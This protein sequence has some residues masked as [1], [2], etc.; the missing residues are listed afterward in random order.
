MQKLVPVPNHKFRKFLEY[1]GCEFKRPKGDH[2]IYTR[3]DLKRP[4]VFRATGDVPIFHIKS[5]LRTLNISTKE[6]VETMNKL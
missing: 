6:F 2:V 4:I 1:V 5:N 3:H